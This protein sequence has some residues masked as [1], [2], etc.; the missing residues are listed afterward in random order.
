ME[1][2]SLHNLNKLDSK[3]SIMQIYIKNVT[4]P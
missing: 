3:N 2:Q 1:Y 4:I